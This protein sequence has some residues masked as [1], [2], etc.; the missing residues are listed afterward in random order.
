MPEKEEMYSQG[1]ELWNNQGYVYLSS[2][3]EALFSAPLDNTQPLENT[4]P[5]FGE[6]IR[7]GIAIVKDWIKNPKG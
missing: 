5:F 6:H 7:E 4:E 2:D 1:S 3:V